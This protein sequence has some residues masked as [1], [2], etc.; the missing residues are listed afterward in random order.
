[1]H[2]S[3]DVA[4]VACNGRVGRSPE[5]LDVGLARQDDRHVDPAAERLHLLDDAV[6]EVAE[7]KDRT[8][9]LVDDLPLLG[10]GLG[11]PLAVAT[12]EPD[13]V[14]LR[15]D[16]AHVLGDIAG[17]VGQVVDREGRRDD[18]DLGPD[19]RRE[20]DLA[21]DGLSDPGDQG[22]VVARD[23]AEKHDL[24]RE[25]VFLD[26]VSAEVRD[27]VHDLV[28]AVDSSLV[29]DRHEDHGA[30]S[31]I[32]AKSARTRLCR[33]SGRVFSLEANQNRP[34]SYLCSRTRKPSGAIERR[35]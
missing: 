15:P 30:A 28:V 6:L 10:R 17:R 5:G 14:R 32:F 7:Q 21:A 16:P 35:A 3:A 4:H 26:H 23:Q 8:V 22:D 29:G 18:R 2:E 27:Q 9:V 33:S 24:G 19:E 31:P 34:F 13:H 12:R 11:D 1:M 20:L 25:H